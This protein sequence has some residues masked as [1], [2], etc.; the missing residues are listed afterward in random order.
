M[1]HR[2]SSFDL[3]QVMKR[4]LGI[5]LLILLPLIA[6]AEADI[7]D[8]MNTESFW[9]NI[10]FRNYKAEKAQKKMIALPKADT[11]FIV[12]SNRETKFGETRFM[13]EERGTDHLNYFLVFLKSGQWNVWHTSLKTAVTAMNQNGRDWVVYTEGFGKIFTTGIYRGFTMTMQYG[14]NVIYL[15]YPSF[16]TRKKIMGNYF[17]ALDNAKQSGDDFAP[18]FDT[19]KTYREAGKMGGGNLTLFFHSMGNNM[20]R[21]MVRNNRIKNINSGKWVNNLVLNSAC[22]P[23]KHHKEW[24]D[25]IHFADRIYIN[26][27]PKD[28]TLSGANFMSLKKQLGQEQKASRSTQAIYVNFDDLCNHNHSNFMQ[29]VARKP[30]MPAAIAYY[31]TLFHGGCVQLEDGKCFKPNAFSKAD[32]TIL[33]AVLDPDVTQPATASVAGDSTADKK[34]EKK[35]P[36]ATKNTTPGPAGGNASSTMLR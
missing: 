23:Q 12:A 34:D 31:A 17:F 4:L 33:D 35:V 5:A 11:M 14:V 21:E 7:I 29:M 13:S 10:A 36:T 24:V 3:L 6:G 20:I 28:A 27:N 30:I 9:K 1:N 22:V 26:Y 8:S 25:R 2:K 32:Y 16:N 15:D 19:L 18:V